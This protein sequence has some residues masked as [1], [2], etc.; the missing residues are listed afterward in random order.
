MQPSSPSPL[1][2]RISYC[3][4]IFSNITQQIVKR[5][6]IINFLYLLLQPVFALQQKPFYPGVLIVP[7]ARK[8]ENTP[9]EPEQGNA[10]E[11]KVH[12]FIHTCSSTPLAH[13]CSQNNFRTIEHKPNEK[14]FGNNNSSSPGCYCTRASKRERH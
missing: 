4:F 6:I 11:G 9:V 12:L 8:A 10:C 13:S 14:S 1:L 3:A 2:I 5:Y 7:H